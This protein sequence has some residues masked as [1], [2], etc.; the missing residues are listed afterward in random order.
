VLARVADP[1]L[2]YGTDEDTWGPDPYARRYDFGKDPLSHAQNQVLLAQEHRAKIVDKFVKAGDNWSKARRGYQ[3][4]LSTQV[5]AVMMMGGWLGGSFINRDH[6]GD[7]NERRPIEVVPAADQRA[8]L[9]F[10]TENAFTDEAYGLTPDL[11]AHLSVDKWFDMENAF[12]N[13]TWGVHDKIGGI[14]AATLSLILNPTILSRI[15]DNE[16]SLPADQ[17]A[18]TLPELLDTVRDGIWDELDK[19]DAAKNYTSRLPLISSLQRNLQREHLERMLDLAASKLIGS[20]AKP[21]SDLAL[22]QL[23]GLKA[24]LGNVANLPNL[25]PYSRAHLRE[26]GNRITKLQESRYLLSK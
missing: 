20:A 22:A 10:I 19:V 26:A 21:V 12:E 2:V 23:D 17:D 14:Q 13:P 16:F 9:K 7:P 4:T 3:L 8:A 25:D 18:L 11:M 6:K 1:L 5:R 15:Y 24:K